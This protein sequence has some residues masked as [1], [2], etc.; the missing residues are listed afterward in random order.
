MRILAFSD[1]HRNEAVTRQIV[2]ESRA[3]DILI[4]AGDF[5]TKGLGLSDTLNILAKANAPVLM[6]AGNHDPFDELQTICDAVPNFTLLDGTGVILDG[7]CFYG[8]SREISSEKGPRWSEVRS[9]IEAHRLLADCPKDAVLI[10]HSPPYGVVDFQVN[11][12]HEGSK[13]L[14][15]TVQE[16]EPFLHLCGHVHHCLGMHE[17]VGK[18]KVMNLG[19]SLNWIDL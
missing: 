17:Y 1:L 11:G 12:R 10:S 5:A 18:T 19:P 15:K 6:V 8:I 14:L 16:K 7:Q 3:A 9:E 2:A 13:T 4:G